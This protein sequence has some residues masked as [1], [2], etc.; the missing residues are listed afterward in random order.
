MN[1]KKNTKKLI[2]AEALV[3]VIKDIIE[4]LKRHT[5]PDAFGTMEEC[6]CAAEIEALDLVL[7]IIKKM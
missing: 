6:L 1:E 5:T 2:D 3:S 4:N 7:D